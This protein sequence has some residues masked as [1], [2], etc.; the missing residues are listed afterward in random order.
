MKTPTPNHQQNSSHNKPLLIAILLIFLSIACFYLV[1]P[2]FGITLAITGIAWGILIGTIALFSIA[3]L[4]FFIIPGILI[5]GIS[6]IAFIWVI[7]AI[8]FFPVIFPVVIPIFIILIFL[9]YMRRRRI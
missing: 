1:F 9:A 2:I 3:A 5:L 8:I 6:I 4:L 7:L